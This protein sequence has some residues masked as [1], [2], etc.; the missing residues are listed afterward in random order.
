MTW[1]TGAQSKIV[2]GLESA[3][4]TVATAGFVL[5]FNSCSLRPDRQ[6]NT[7]KTIR[8]N[9]NP[10]EPFDGNLSISGN[11]TVPVDS[12][13][14]WYWLR[15]ACGTPVTTGADPYAHV[16]TLGGARD[17]ITLEEQ[18]LDLDTPLYYRYRGV[19]VSSMKI[20]L[21]GDG[22][23][24]CDFGLVAATYSEETS[25]FDAS[26]TVITEARLQNR[27]LAMTEGGSSI[28][29][30]TSLDFDVAF[31]LD[32][33]TYC[34]GGGGEIGQAPDQIYDYKGSIKALFEDSS[35]YTKARNSTESSIV[36]TLTNG[37]S[38]ILS[39]NF[40]ELKYSE[41]APSIDGPQ[42]ILVDLN[43]VAY[44]SNATEATGFQITLTNG[45]A[46]A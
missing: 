18:Y 42:G 36:A 2:A 17:S 13:A 28:S 25:P 45:D 20:G 34:I 40:P 41:N 15:Y 26:P 38:S 37:A 1:G 14:F 43:F 16:W 33:S 31:N 6:Q 3:Y 4:K 46:H 5:P 27:H 11:I 19:K 7:P 8:G 10:A 35:L 44:Y 30:A 22:E 12:V 24:T 32:S 21:G 9:L 23:L 29:N 39:F